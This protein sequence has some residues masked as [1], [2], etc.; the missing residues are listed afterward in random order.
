[1]KRWF[2]IA[3]GAYM[4]LFAAMFL[5]TGNTSK[6]VT[7]LSVRETQSRLIDA[8]EDSL[9]L[10]F[11]ISDSDTFITDQTNIVGS[12]LKG[13]SSEMAVEVAGISIDMEPVRYR[14]ETFFPIRLTI[15]F[16]EVRIPGSEVVF[17]DAA[18]VLEY[19][20]GA[21]FDLELGNLTLLFSDVTSP[22]H[23]DFNRLYAVMGDTE[24]RDY[25]AGIVIGMDCFTLGEIEIDRIDCGI[26]AVAIKLGSATILDAAP[27]FDSDL[28]TLVPGFDPYSDAM[29][30]DSE[31]MVGG[32]KY[33]FVPFGYPEGI[34]A[35]IKR[36]YI[37]IDYEYFDQGYEFIIDDF[38]FYQHQP[39]VGDMDDEICRYLY[40]Y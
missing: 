11:Y 35:T 15:N 34:D 39:L 27:S 20:N 22:L 36:F 24:G 17:A 31:L 21:S 16:Q 6:S 32:A 23:F 18:L 5:I 19:R 25:V 28:E 26:E 9:D 40:Q 8:D 33:L 14:T 3:F 10:G 1:M 37:V 4:L 38:V 29:P 2:L 7:I 13:N 12:S 30:S